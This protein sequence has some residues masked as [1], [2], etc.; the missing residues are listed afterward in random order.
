M[1]ARNAGSVEARGGA[2][3]DDQAAGAF[4]DLFI[5]HW[6]S[7]YRLLLRMVG[8]PAEA[9][10]IAL[11]TF[12]QL[13]RQPPKNGPELNLGGWLYRVATNLGLRSIRGFKRRQR[14]ELAAGRNALENPAEDQPVEVFEGKEKKRL[15]R[16]AL[17][18]IN[19][20]RA[21]ILVLR[22]SGLAYK[23]IAKALGLAPASI[24]PL[25]LRAERDFEQA[26]RALAREEP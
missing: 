4:E 22:Y 16:L 18:R 15:A 23:D 5:E 19:P 2:A 8:D 1:K 12:Y 13:Y 21:E 7:V 14:Y 26:Y 3:T 25:L 17:A 10:D 11:E 20:R 9:E 6:A 24:G